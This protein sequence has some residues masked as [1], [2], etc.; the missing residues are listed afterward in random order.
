METV[1]RRKT[2]MQLRG[3]AVS[4]D[5]KGKAIVTV[6]GRLHTAESRCSCLRRIPRRWQTSR[7]HLCRLC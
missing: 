5:K 3:T 7:R 6:D 4:S 1:A 2:R